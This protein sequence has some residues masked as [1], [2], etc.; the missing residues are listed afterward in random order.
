MFFKNLNILINRKEKKYFFVITILLFISSILETVGIAIFLPIINLVFNNSLADNFWIKNLNNFFQIDILN[1][2]LILL[3]LLL[4]F[5]IK[6][7]LFL[8]FMFIRI[9]I[10]NY[11]RQQ[12]KI[13]LLKI[14]LNL[15]YSKFTNREKSELLRNLYHEV[16]NFT[17]NFVMPIIEFIYIFFILI[18]VLFFLVIYDAKI[19]SFFILSVISFFFIFY[20]ITKKHLLMYGS[21]RAKY[22][23]ILLRKIPD[24]FKGYIEIKLFDLKTKVID[25]FMKYQR[26]LDRIQIPQSIIAN[27]PRSFLELFVITSFTILLAYQFDSNDNMLLTVAKLSIY[28]VV[29][30]KIFPYINGISNIFS[31]IM[32]GFTSYNI[33]A[34]EFKDSKMNNMEHLEVINEKIKEI[35]FSEVH[36]DY[37]DDNLKKINIL[38]N[39][40]LKIKSND[41]IGIIGK[42]GSGKTT[43]LNLLIGLLKPTKGNIKLND[44][45]LNEI[46]LE[47][48]YHK[49]SYIPQEPFFLYDTVKSN[50]VSSDISKPVDN[51]KIID[52]LKK[53][54]LDNKFVQNGNI[55]NE[56]I[57]ENASNLSGGEKQRLAIA[58]AIYSDCEVMILDEITNKLDLETR[59]EIIDLISS[60]K[61]SKTVII[62]SHDQDTIEKCNNIFELKNK[63]LIKKI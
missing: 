62:V 19:T 32:R 44:K 35:K 27:I 60:F 47:K 8:F 57:G 17:E 41:F 28:A 25:E 61:N 36:F 29:I 46:N 33:L 20:F 37:F 12:K 55:S 38:E 50:I 22:S 16:D 30:I 1:L 7:F 18:N 4:I 42:S 9:K 48:L 23:K 24:A 51:K 3:S 40:D 31:R 26:R 45:K 52:I 53:T 56:F 49:F 21:D 14:Y 2:N 43:L 13:K 63:K 6:N 58:R 15:D 34:N 5:F 54:K 10:I 11:Y 59:K 39:V